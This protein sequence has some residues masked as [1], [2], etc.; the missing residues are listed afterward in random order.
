MKVKNK[1]LLSMSNFILTDR[2]AVEQFTN[3]VKN[4]KKIPWTDKDLSLS[5]RLNVI[6]REP[7]Y[8]ALCIK[9]GKRKTDIFIK[10]MIMDFKY[11][12]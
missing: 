3:W 7:V 6:K 2:L 5:E 11:E 8:I 10:S 9:H 1:D 12:S 4:C